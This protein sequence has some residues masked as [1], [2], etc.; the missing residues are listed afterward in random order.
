VCLFS[1]SFLD[2]SGLITVG[3]E[4]DVFLVEGKEAF[5]GKLTMARCPRIFRAAE[6]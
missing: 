4:E 2:T 5:K 3:A 1:F 6:S